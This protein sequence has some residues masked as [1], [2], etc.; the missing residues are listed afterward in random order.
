MLIG[1]AFFLYKPRA[2]SI[3]IYVSDC[4]LD[5]SFPLYDP[6]TGLSDVIA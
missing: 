4:P 6:R 1:M 5:I 3:F 2:V